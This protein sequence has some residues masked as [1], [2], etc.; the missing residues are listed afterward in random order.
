MRQRVALCRALIHEPKLLLMD[1]RLVR[2]TN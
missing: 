1:S 2:S